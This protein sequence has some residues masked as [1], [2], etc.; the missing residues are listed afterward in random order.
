MNYSIFI[1]NVNKLISAEA[2]INNLDLKLLLIIKKHLF[3]AGNPICSLLK[4]QTASSSC[5]HVSES[6]KNQCV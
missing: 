4:E 1:I 2:S 5:F 6:E 3:L